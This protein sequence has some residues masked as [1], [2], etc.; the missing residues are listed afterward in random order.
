MLGDRPGRI[1]WIPD[2]DAPN[3]F[4]CRVPELGMEFKKTIDTTLDLTVIYTRR[5]GPDNKWRVAGEV[6]Y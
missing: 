5:L 6:R 3:T 4:R 1:I 2:P